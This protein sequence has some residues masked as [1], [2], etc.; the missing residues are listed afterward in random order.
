MVS[1]AG[2]ANRPTGIARP[3]SA[4]GIC[5][6]LSVAYI[7]QLVVIHDSTTL[8]FLSLSL[9]LSRPGMFILHITQLVQAS[10]CESTAEFNRRRIEA[11]YLH[12]VL[13]NVRERAPL[14]D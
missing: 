12:C 1:K 9:S 3:Q 6:W 13:I 11:N 4:F 10:Q 8:S 2:T 5:L 14:Q 7:G